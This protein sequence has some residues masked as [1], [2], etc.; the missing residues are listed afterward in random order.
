MLNYDFQNLLSSFEFECFSRDILNAHEGLNL[1][2]FAEGRDGGVDLR[3][4]YGRDGKAVI[5]QAKRYKDYSKLKSNLSKEIEKVKKLKPTR[6]MLTTSVDL[7]D[8]NKQELKSMF[9]PYIKND[10]DILGKQDLNKLLAKHPDVEQQYYK[11]WLASTPVLVN[12][13]K[14][15][16][17]NWTNFEKDEIRDT[18]K[19]YV[20]N[21][22]FRDALQKLINNRYVIIS[23]EPG[24]GKTTLARVLIMHLLSEKFKDKIDSANFEE[25]YYTS[26]NIE[27]LANVLQEGKRQVF[28]F[29]DFLGHISLDEGEKNFDSRIIQFI[30]ACQ[31]SRDKLLILT[32][33]EYILQQGLARYDNF[34]KGKGIE[35]S[36]CVVDMGKYTRFVR[37]EILYNHLV[38]NDIPQPYINAILENKNYLKLI[39]HPHYSPRVIET[40]ITNGTHENCEPEEYFKVVLGFFDHPDSVWLSAFNRLDDV[41]QEALLVLNTM[42][43]IVMYD[44]WR[45]A[46]HYFFT[47]VHQEANYLKDQKWNEMVKVLQ[48]NFI[49]TRKGKAGMYVEFHNPGIIDVLSRYINGNK[50]VKLLLLK[51]A[52]Y[53][54]QVFGV[55]KDDRRTFHHAMVSEEFHQQFIE[56]FDRI[57]VDYRSC[58]VRLHQQSEKVEYYVRSPRTR[59]DSLR[60]LLYDYEDMLI[61][62]P[63]YVEQKM[64]QAV[65]SEE[66]NG[67]LASQLGL[68]E[69]VDLSKTNL[70]I[71][72]L[73]ESYCYRIKESADCLNLVTSMEKVFPTHT[74]Y[75][76]SDE[77]CNLTAQHLQQE[78]NDTSDSG[79]EELD[80]TAQELCK[81]I[82]SLEYEPIVGEIKKA[83]EDFSDKIDAE[84][85]AYEDDYRYRDDSYHG[86]NAWE[87]DNLFSTIKEG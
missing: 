6:Y 70:D 22:S 86:E 84:A 15:N 50:N 60:W 56:A 82:P 19:T 62:I 21:D 11:L 48:N 85:E 63:G 38:A 61:K 8:G 34:T 77:F 53:I 7:T 39:D 13:L 10:N 64:T 44:D 52:Y 72:E 18:I 73:F 45:E 71:D 51:N 80:D 65:M 66:Q 49:K 31:R 1:A 2:S 81:Y 83:Y 30:K 87:I 4:T 67:D 9:T 79:L 55:F 69:K 23:G 14:K 16:I 75:I 74:A 54:D 37:A 27:D 25:F 36:K 35:V 40:F 76:E 68:L 47:R 58:L 78:L 29:D 46:Y 26:S 5:V 12:I 20:M 24:I 43:A 3:Y 57:W 42:G 28:F 32:T 33:R 17:V 59:V 41:A